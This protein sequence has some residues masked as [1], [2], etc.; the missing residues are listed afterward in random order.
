MFSEPDASLNK[1][2]VSIYEQYFSLTRDGAL[3]SEH[4]LGGRLVFAGDLQGNGRDLLFAANVAGAASL[5]ASADPLVQRQAVRDGVVD[6]LVTSL[7]EALRILKN[8]VRKRQAVSVGVGIDPGKLAAAMLDRGVLPD[9]LLPAWKSPLSEAQVERF[10]ADG[11]RS[12]VSGASLQQQFVTWAV[13]RDF[14]RWL[15]R[16]DACLHSVIPGSDLVRQRWLRLAPRYL[17]RMVQRQHGMTLTLAEA[18]V[19]RKRAAALIETAIVE[20]KEPVQLRIDS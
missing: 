5:A 10:E 9:L 8:E 1:S 2:I 19:F 17:G 4:G 7:E 18:D 14:V 12:I 6:F 11:A 13:D 15:P 3:D 16:L 20:G